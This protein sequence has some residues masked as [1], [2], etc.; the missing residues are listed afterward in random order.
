MSI[1][2]FRRHGRSQTKF[3]EGWI[4]VCMH[5]ILSYLPAVLGF[6]TVKICGAWWLIGRFVTFRLECRMQVESRSSRHV[7]TLGKSFARSYLWRFGMKLRHSIC[8]RQQK[9]RAMNGA[10]LASPIRGELGYAH[11]PQLG[12]QI[13]CPNGNQI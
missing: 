9:F 7:G 10:H 12:S 5:R 1:L 3:G 6:I 4:W 11:R 2:L 13:H 8:P